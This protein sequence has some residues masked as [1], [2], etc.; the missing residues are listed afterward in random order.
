LIGVTVTAELVES[1]ASPGAAEQPAAKAPSAGTRTQ[2][3]SKRE[4]IEDMTV[5]P[6][7]RKAE[8]G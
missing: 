2:E 8:K 7:G 6:I 1:V 3:A 5:T 4:E